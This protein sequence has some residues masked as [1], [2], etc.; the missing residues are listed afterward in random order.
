MNEEFDFDSKL[1][2][3]DPFFDILKSGDELGFDIEENVNSN[4]DEVAKT[5]IDNYTRMRKGYII[6][7]LKLFRQ[8]VHTLKGFF[9]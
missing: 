4:F 8:G 3:Q 9:A 1:L 6:R 2:K 5:I 7:D